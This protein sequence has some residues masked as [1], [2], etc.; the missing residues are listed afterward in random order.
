VIGFRRRPLKREQ[1][2]R[3]LAKKYHVEEQ[4]LR[5]LHQAEGGAK[6]ADIY[7]EHGSG[8][9]DLLRVKKYSGLRLSELR[10]L[11][12]LREE[13]AK[14]KRLVAHLSL[15]RHVLQQLVQNKL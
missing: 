15:D 4:I 6:V 10:Q 14:L 1:E 11:W 3:K 8:R 2:D 12:Q 7:R 5:A 9:S 13:N